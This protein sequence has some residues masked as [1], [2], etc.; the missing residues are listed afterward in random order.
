MNLED[1]F[2]FKGAR[3]HEESRDLNLPLTRLF[4]QITLDYLGHAV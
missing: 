4:E 3:P 2:V 1:A